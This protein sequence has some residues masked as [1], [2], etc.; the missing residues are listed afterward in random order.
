[1]SRRE[2]TQP[3]AFWKSLN[4]NEQCYECR[5]RIKLR[6]CAICSRLFCAGCC[7]HRY[8]RFGEYEAQFAGFVVC[9]CTLCIPKF[10]EMA[11][12]EQPIKRSFFKRYGFR[13]YY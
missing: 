3:G 8:N 13:S 4:I 7:H 11:K 6:P 9:V 5:G 2:Y 10:D 12:R 1:M